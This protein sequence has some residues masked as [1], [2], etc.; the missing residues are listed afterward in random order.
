[1]YLKAIGRTFC[2]LPPDGSEFAVTM[3]TSNMKPS[4]SNAGVSRRRFLAA[5]GAAVALPAF[6]PGRVLGLGGQASPSQRINIG[7]VGCGGQGNGNTDGFLRNTD[8]RVVAA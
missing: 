5:A 8:C 1:M 4:E 6:V 3:G 7:V 2:G